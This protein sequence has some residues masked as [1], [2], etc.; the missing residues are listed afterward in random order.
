MG[1]LRVWILWSKTS[2]SVKMNQEIRVWLMWCHGNCYTWH[3]FVYTYRTPRTIHGSF[4]IVIVQ[5]PPND[6]YKSQGSPQSC[7]CWISQDPVAR[8]PSSSNHPFSGV[9]LV[10]GR[11]G[12]LEATKKCDIILMKSLQP[13]GVFVWIVS[14][15][16]Y[17]IT[18]K[19]IW[20]QRTRT[21]LNQERNAFNGHISFLHRL[22][23][24]NSLERKYFYF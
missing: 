15:G 10:L 21:H 6:Y 17:S 8:K 19:K 4:G 3:F 14:A 11:V 9:T 22:S 24:G 7:T 20:I 16:S 5:N 2:D 1:Y 18:T 13:M 23:L 12:D